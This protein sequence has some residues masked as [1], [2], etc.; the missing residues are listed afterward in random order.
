MD[1]SIL[2]TPIVSK[3][4]LPYLRRNYVLPIRGRFMVYHL[5]HSSH[6]LICMDKESSHQFIEIKAL[7]N[8][9]WHCSSNG[10]YHCYHQR[11]HGSYA[12]SDADHGPKE[13]GYPRISFCWPQLEINSSWCFRSINMTSLNFFSLNIFVN[14]LSTSKH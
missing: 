2:N 1:N 13:N 3:C 11:E 12:S 14:S 10:H 4:L 7:N 5:L 6:I 9:R 8:L